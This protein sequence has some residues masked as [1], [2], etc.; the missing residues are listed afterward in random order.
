LSDA[1]AFEDVDRRD[2]VLVQ[3]LRRVARAESNVCV[4]SEVKY[5]VRPAHR[6]GKRARVQRIA[7][8]QSE[9]HVLLCVGEKLFSPSREVVEANDRMAQT[10]QT[11]SQVRTNE[12]SRP[13][14]KASH[15]AVRPTKSADSVGA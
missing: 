13:R 1:H 8:H 11:V 4:R 2:G 5:D 15:R 12:T 14:D 10:E 9:T 3:V 6:L 7:T